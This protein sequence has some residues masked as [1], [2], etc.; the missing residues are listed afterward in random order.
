MVSNEV[1][2]RDVCDGRLH[3]GD[4]LVRRCGSGE[5]TDFTSADG[6]QPPGVL[7]RSDGQEVV[8]KG[9]AQ[10]V[11]L[12]LGGNHLELDR[13]LRE[14]RIATCGVQDARDCS[15]MNIAVLLRE[16]L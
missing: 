4:D 14:R 8:T 10:E 16:L 13:R 5:R 12:E 11:D 15:G 1:S 3:E 9:G 2:F 6:E 7:Y